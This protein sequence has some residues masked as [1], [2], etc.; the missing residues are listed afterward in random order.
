MSN[1]NANY[2]NMS[3]S[4]KKKESK[5]RGKNIYFPYLIF[6]LFTCMNKYFVLRKQPVK[7]TK[8]QINNIKIKKID[9]DI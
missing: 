2:T 5:R 7:R 8:E 9:I 1:E 4:S 3:I 6:S